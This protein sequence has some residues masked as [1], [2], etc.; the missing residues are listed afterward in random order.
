MAQEVRVLC[1]VM[2]NST[3]KSTEAAHLKKT[4][5]RHCNKLIFMGDANLKG[6]QYFFINGIYMQKK[7][8]DSTLHIVDTK[9]ESHRSGSWAKTIESYTHVWNNMKDTFDWVIKVDDTKYIL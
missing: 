2:I 8:I 9:D 1:M 7:I 4:W 5:G 3:Q 6:P